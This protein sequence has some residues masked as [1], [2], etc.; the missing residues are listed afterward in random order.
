MKKVWY[1]IDM[2]YIE[3]KEYF[4]DIETTENYS[5]YM[6]SVADAITI[7]ILGSICGLKNVSQI[8]QWASSEKISKFL[9]EEFAINAVPCYFWLLTLLKMI[10]PE[11]L[12]Q[13]FVKFTEAL[14]PQK[15][16]V[17]SVDG[18]TIR[19]TAKM[20]S[21]EKPLHIISA[22][23]S[24][25]KMTLAQK[26]CSGKSNEIPTVKELLNSLNIK[27]AVL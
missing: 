20:D 5:G 22:Q 18:K 27:R 1:N 4:T 21:Y 15:K 23:I 14:L 8:H 11:S 19:S 9:K 13:C 26:T 17:I 2:E 6:Y 12:N 16:K 10:K 3:I 25:L 24:E 7:A